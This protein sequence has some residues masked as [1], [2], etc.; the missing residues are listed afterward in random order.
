[1]TDS[2]HTNYTNTAVGKLK[3]TLSFQG[4]QPSTHRLFSRC[5]P[6]AR[7]YGF[8]I[9]FLPGTRGSYKTIRSLASSQDYFMH[10][11][12]QVPFDYFAI[13]HN[14]DVT[15]LSG[16][17]VERQSR[18]TK[19][20]IDVILSMYRG[21]VDPPQSVLLVGH[22]LGVISVLNLLS[23]PEFDQRKVTTVFALAGPLLD[24][25]FSPGPRM[26]LV[27]DKIGRYFFTLA[28]NSSRSSS[29]VLLSL[30]GG[31]RD[32]L[33]PDVL[34]RIDFRFTELNVLSLSTSAVSYVWAPCDHLCILW[35]RQ[36]VYALTSALLDMKF[37]S[38]AVDLLH[39]PTRLRLLQQR[40]IT[41]PV[42]LEKH[43]IRYLPTRS[44]MPH[45]D[46]FPRMT[47]LYKTG[48]NHLHY[49]GSLPPEGAY[50][51]LGPFFHDSSQ[52]VLIM[53][54]HFIDV[55]TLS[56]VMQSPS[57]FLCRS[58]TD[59]ATDETPCTHMYA[60]ASDSSYV[61]RMPAFSSRYPYTTAL[62]SLPEVQL[63]GGRLDD[64]ITYGYPALGIYVVLTFPPYF[65]QGLFIKP[66]ASIQVESFESV[67]GRVDH[68]L[69]I[70]FSW[71]PMSRPIRCPIRRTYVV[72]DVEHNNFSSIFHRLIFPNDRFL[73]SP[74]L[75]APR[76]S[77]LVEN[78]TRNVDAE[79]AGLVT[80]HVPWS[81]HFYSSF[82]SPIKTNIIDLE[83]PSPQPEKL[84]ENQ[85][86][87]IDLYLNPYCTETI[88]VHYSII[89]WL[90]KL[91]RLHWP[92]LFGIIYAHLLIELTIALLAWP[93]VMRNLPTLFV[94]MRCPSSIVLARFP[95]GSRSGSRYLTC[96]GDASKM[97]QNGKP[98]SL[99][100]EETWY[101]H[102]SFFIHIVAALL[103]LMSFHL[104]NFPTSDWIHM[105]KY[106]HLGLRYD[107]FLAYPS[108]ISSLNWVLAHCP[109]L[110]LTI[111]LSILVPWFLT[112]LL[113]VQCW[114]G[115]WFARI[116]LR[117]FNGGNLIQHRRQHQ[118]SCFLL[119]TTL[120]LGG[121]VSEAVG[122]LLLA[123][124][125]RFRIH[126]KVVHSIIQNS[127]S[128]GKSRSPMEKYHGS[129]LSHHLA[130]PYLVF[131]TLIMLSLLLPENW[132]SVFFRLQHYMRTGP[133]AF[134]LLLRAPFIPS[135]VYLLFIFVALTCLTWL[136]GLRTPDNDPSD[137]QAVTNH[138][139]YVSNSIV[140]LLCLT[141]C[142]VYVFLLLHT[143]IFYFR[144]MLFCSS[145][146]VL[147]LS[148]S[149]YLTSELQ[150]FRPWLSGLRLVKPK[151]H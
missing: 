151:S 35:C 54:R 67:D 129:S 85:S 56:P 127:S 147:L 45:M 113:A 25:I 2:V 101:Q 60:V 5:G 144:I 29:L 19:I 34:G 97:I 114:S 92:H 119:I 12:D 100:S 26:D 68:V 66:Q 74:S 23:N 50:I 148:L 131:T 86:A 128:L 59:A 8:P 99:T 3:L 136:T 106:G 135:D 77:I 82:I 116:H 98:P 94:A 30:T 49:Q 22:S 43:V 44:Q 32:V 41:R 48:R 91:L 79:S 78:C 7:R 133:F 64:P 38:P 122:I 16:D 4:S 108:K 142:S 124:F 84:L 72:E 96:S 61:T 89:Q 81:N 62:L 69:D 87:F 52:R 121:L 14:E 107:D 42:Q 36:L 102:Y 149:V 141:G 31:S 46:N 104:V 118:I 150:Q 105:Q 83:V 120:L 139:S 115:H 28:S 111:P 18:F 90:A 75:P 33:V 47:W 110:L 125:L 55:D 71:F 134:H 73:F 140:V 130:F 76:L 58:S 109:L 126:L 24:P 112:L 123:I 37:T 20:V 15:A 57:I 21:T 65:P 39:A 80:W 63:P 103:H 138:K 53:A 95:R 6:V 88:S 145:G 17:A 93:P 51:K 10:G 9:L 143:A 137:T 117:F 146:L 70:P 132:V 11:A 13:D 40:L 27:Y 1:M